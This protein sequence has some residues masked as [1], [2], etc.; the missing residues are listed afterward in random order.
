MFRNHSNDSRVITLSKMYL[1]VMYLS[2]VYIY[3]VGHKILQLTE[4]CGRCFF[5]FVS[6]NIQNTTV[7]VL[8]K[9]SL[10]VINKQTIVTNTSMIRHAIFVS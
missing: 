1:L 7:I 8:G 4:R 6:D 2:S 10:I 3:I 9:K 5:I